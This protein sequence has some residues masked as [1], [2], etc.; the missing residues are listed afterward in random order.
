MESKSTKNVSCVEEIGAKNLNDKKVSPTAF[1]IKKALKVNKRLAFYFIAKFISSLAVPFLGSLLAACAVHMLAGGYEI[2][3]YFGAMAGLA[4]LT[5]AFEVIKIY[6]TERYQWQSTFVRCGDFL[7][8][9]AEKSLT[10]DYDKIEP[11]ECQTKLW[12][13][14]EALGSNWVGVEGMLKDLST[15]S[16]SFAGMLFYGALTGFYCPYALLPLIFSVAADLFFT[17][18]AGKLY[19][20]SREKINECSREN[21]YLRSVSKSAYGKDIRAFKLENW[22]IKKSE[23]LIKRRIDAERNYRL[24]NLGKDL[25]GVFFNVARE[26]VTYLVLAS[27][28]I[29]GEMS[30][31]SFTFVTGLTAGFSTWLSDFSGSAYRLHSHSKQVAAYRDFLEDNGQEKAARE[32]AVTAPVEIELENVSFTYPGAEKPVLNGVS[33]KIPAGGKVALVGNN[34]AGKTTLV[35][36]LCGLYRPTSGVIKINGEDISKFPREEYY[37]LISA[38]FQ[39]SNLFAFGV[40]DNVTCTDGDKANEPA[41]WQAI[42]K[43]GLTQKIRDLPKAEKTFVTREFDKN[44]VDFSG[45]EK[46]RL[47]LARAIYKNAPILLLDEPTAALDP[48]NEEKIYKLYQSLAQGVTSVFI[49]HRLAST[50]FCDEILVLNGGKISER[51]TH[52]QLMKNGGEYAA[53]FE[54]QA[55]YYADDAEKTKSD[56]SGESIVCGENSENGNSLEEQLNGEGAL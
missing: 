47:M 7:C 26:A 42:E 23:Q 37:K 45:G 36:L 30:I 14:F 29:G 18:T 11:R 38:A 52:E 3:E 43:A 13:A 17:V 27:T 10:D 48:I 15:A 55:K 56:K 35:K 8:E 51:G 24:N 40:Q 5:L 33:F 19:E 41:F 4:V 22:L 53:L 32:V 2:S 16:V 46:Q 44:G 28:V 25:T 54:V 1:V 39:E 9:V 50:R 34:G 20:R 49:S 12:A 6:S 21:D 31:A